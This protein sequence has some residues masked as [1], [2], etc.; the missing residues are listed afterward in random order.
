MKVDLDKLRDSCW[1]DFRGS[2]ETLIPNIES[3]YVALDNEDLVLVSDQLSLVVTM[4]LESHTKMRLL[5]LLDAIE[6]EMGAES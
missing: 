5:F 2:L 6:R 4:L 3:I 1:E